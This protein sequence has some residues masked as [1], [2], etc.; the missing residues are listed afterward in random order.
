MYSIFVFLI[1]LKPIEIV[2]FDLYSIY[3]TSVYVTNIEWLQTIKL[4]NFIS[5][6]S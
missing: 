5:I 2:Y 1:H 3:K 6:Y 4:K